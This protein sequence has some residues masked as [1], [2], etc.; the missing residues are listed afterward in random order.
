LARI[1][2]LRGVL[3]DEQKVL[4]IIKEELQEI[5][6]KF[7]DPRRTVI[8][9]ED[10]TLEAEDLIPEEEVVIT[11][12]NQGYIKRMP[13]DTYRSQKRGG[14]GITA[15]GTKEEDFVRH[16]FIT[17]TH[18][19][20]LFFS[21]R[22]KVYRLK[23]H[24]IPEAG[25]QAKGTALVNLIYIG[26]QERITAVIPV[27]EFSSGLYLFMATRFGVVK[28]T[29]LQQFDT[30]RRDGIIAIKLDE[31][32]ELVEVKLTSGRE[33]IML[34]TRQGLVIRFP[35]GEVHPYGRNAR[36]V[37]G[38]SLQPGDTVVA[39]DIVRTEGDVL[40]VTANG[41]GKRTPV[42][43][44]R[45]QSR[46]G[47]GI[48]GARVTGRTGPVVAMQ[49]VKPEE[50]IMVISAEGIIIRLRAID[51]STMGRATQGVMLMRLAPGDKLVAAALVSGEE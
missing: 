38:I 12:T 17:S 1:A 26:Q 15:M 14:R 8:S 40:V 5:R 13:L 25:R 31:E 51:I 2:Y 11:I 23:V 3:A 35:E 39:M 45:L 47:K 22:G 36:G 42:A 46:G 44:Y 28:K 7:A 20:F 30:S 41:Y 43:D 10:T 6:Q 19:Y 4:Q 21:N 33:E 16:L 50:E 18:H 32:D 24:E 49:V 48:I 27:R 9:D 34:C 29:E 37:K